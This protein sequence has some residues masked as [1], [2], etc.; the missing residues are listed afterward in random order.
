MM[1]IAKSL[2]LS[3]LLQMM[4][5]SVVD[6]HLPSGVLHWPSAG[7]VKLKHIQSQQTSCINAL[8]IAVTM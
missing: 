1:D 8:P 3:F 5:D 7:F 2:L 6:Q 4:F